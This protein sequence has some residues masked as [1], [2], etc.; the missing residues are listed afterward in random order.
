MAA[1]YFLKINGIDGESADADHK[2]EIDVMSWSWGA[3]N[4]GTMSWGGGGGAGKVQMNDFSFTMHMN[5]ASPKLAHACAT[6]QH[7]AT[8]VLTCRRAGGKQEKYLVITFTD[9]MVSSYQT[10][11]SGDGGIPL[12]SIT[13]NFAKIETEYFVQDKSGSTAS[14]GKFTYDLKQ[15][16]AA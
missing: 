4:A 11:G 13:L 8:A 6:G 10:G 9:V 7:I 15:N 2:N 3:S 5:K 12:E 14:A 1:D 16:K